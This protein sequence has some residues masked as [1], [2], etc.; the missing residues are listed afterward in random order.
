MIKPG[1]LIVAEV[2]KT[3]PFIS[4]K[5]WHIATLQGSAESSNTKDNV[6]KRWKTPQPLQALV[7]SIYT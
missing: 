5:I 7:V 4:A 2:P 6:T 3:R 1:N